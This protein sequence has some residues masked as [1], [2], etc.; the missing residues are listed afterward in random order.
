[1]T[2]PPQ[3]HIFNFLLSA[4]PTGHAHFLGESH[5]SAYKALVGRQWSHIT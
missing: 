1:M 5:T 2:A 3:S 4:I